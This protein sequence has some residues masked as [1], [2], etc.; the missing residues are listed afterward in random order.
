MILEGMKKSPEAPGGV[1]DLDPSRMLCCVSNDFH[2][3][4][5]S[6]HLVSWLP[7]LGTKT[8]LIKDYFKVTIDRVYPPMLIRTL[9]L[10]I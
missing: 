5:T 2:R 6:V 3:Q 7:C 10:C 9:N 8:S 1:D 4:N